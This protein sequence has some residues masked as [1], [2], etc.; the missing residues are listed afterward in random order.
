MPIAGNELIILLV[1]AAILI[2]PE[3]LPRYA[4]TVANLVRQARRYVAGAKTQLK[5]ELGSD[6]DNVDWRQYDPRRY[7]P[8]R[9]VREALFEDAPPGPVRP[10]P[11]PSSAGEPDRAPS[12]VWDH[13]SNASG[14]SAEPVGSPQGT[15]PTSAAPTPFDDEAT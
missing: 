9:I 8:R 4:E 10:Q 15:T 11:A 1:L 12:A 14:G 5:S 2:G 13:R 6:F 7:D 3:R